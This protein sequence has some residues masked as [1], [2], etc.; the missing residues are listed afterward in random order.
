MYKRIQQL[1]L[2]QGLS[3]KSITEIIEKVKLH[4]KTLS[5][6]TTFVEQGESCTQLIFILNGLVIRNFQS[7]DHTFNIE[8]EVGSNELIEPDALFGLTPSYQ[9]SYTTATETDVLIIDKNYVVSQLMDYSIFKMNFLNIL[10]GKIHS[11]NQLVWKPTSSNEL[12]D[13]FNS[14]VQ[15]HTLGS[16]SPVTIYITMDNLAFQLNGTRLNVSRMLNNLRDTHK[17]KLKRKTIYIPES[18]LI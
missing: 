17:I 9:A 10:S 3:E 16:D 15:A 2:F 1:P 13:R 11:Y 8:L 5:A 18:K 7:E 12:L 14:F 6:G 4:F